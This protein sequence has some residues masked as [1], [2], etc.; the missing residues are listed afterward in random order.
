MLNFST[1]LCWAFD[2]LLQHPNVSSGRI[3]SNDVP[4]N[5]NLVLLKE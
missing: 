4:K 1:T 3:Y 2:Y 5:E